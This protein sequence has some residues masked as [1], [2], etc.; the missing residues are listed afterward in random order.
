M[1]TIRRCS[2]SLRALGFGMVFGLATLSRA[3]ADEPASSSSGP[4]TSSSPATP[5]APADASNTLSPKLT[6]TLRP[7]VESE[8]SA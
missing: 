6:G 4:T 5:A 2:R 7:P 1:P 3:A 8:N